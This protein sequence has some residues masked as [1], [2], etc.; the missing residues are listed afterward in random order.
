MNQMPMTLEPEC[1]GLDACPV[2]MCGC[3]WLVTGDAWADNSE[4]DKAEAEA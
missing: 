2:A 3:R 1:P 4:G